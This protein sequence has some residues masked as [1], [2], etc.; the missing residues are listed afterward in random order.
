MMTLRQSGF[1][2]SSLDFGSSSLDSDRIE[3][4]TLERHNGESQNKSLADGCFHVFLDVGANMGV[5]GRF[6]LE[7]EKFPLAN[8]SRAIF[9]GQFG[10][11]RDNRDFCAFEFEP[12]PRHKEKLEENRLAYEAMGWRYHVINAAVGVEPGILPFYSRKQSHQDDFRAEPIKGATTII[13]VTVVHF[14]PWLRKHILQRQI[15][16]ITYGKY[17]SPYNKP[18]IVMKMD[19]ERLEFQVLPDMLANGVL[20]QLDFAF[21]EFHGT[22][23]HHSE[24]R[25]GMDQVL[26]NAKVCEGFSYIA[27]DDESYAHD[28]IDLPTPTS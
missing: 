11:H 18:K 7:P 23:P 10:K 15:P 13:N 9:E 20:C 3:V 6:L 17:S 8:K 19:I 12:N 2:P 24:I 1:G 22:G 14:A 16:Q 21:A 4:T 26:S 28:G 5:H 27:A 25:R